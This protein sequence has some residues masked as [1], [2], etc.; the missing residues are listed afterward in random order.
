VPRHLRES[1]KR[2]L[3]GSGA[4]NKR[5][6]IKNVLNL[7]F[8]DSSKVKWWLADESFIPIAKSSTKAVRDIRQDVIP[9]H[10]RIVKRTIFGQTERKNVFIIN[11]PESSGTS[12]VAKVF[13]LVHLTHKLKYR[14]YGLGEAANSIEARRRGIYTSKV[15]GCGHIYN[16]LGLVEASVIIFEH[17]RNANTVRDLMCN[18][19]EDERTEVFMKTVPLFV[20]LYKAGC[21]H[22]DVNSSAVL[23][24]ENDANPKVFLVDFHHAKFY[25][26]PNTEILMFEAGYFVQSCSDFVLTEIVDE[27]LDEL[28]RAI[29]INRTGEIKKMKRCFYYYFKAELSRKHRK[30]II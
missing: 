25:S 19:A 20:S 30:K 18:R 23:L 26:N 11:H 8:R 4:L 3:V 13:F 9:S 24:S 14:L 27:W 29:D 21:H 5:R 28:L 22:I 10:V 17:L 16:A 6:I 15:Y 1:V 7:R 2:T 12:F